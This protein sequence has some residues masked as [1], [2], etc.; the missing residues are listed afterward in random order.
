MILKRALSCG[1][2]TLL[3]TLPT[4]SGCDSEGES[5]VVVGAEAEADGDA[6]KKEKKA[7]L[8]AKA[9]LDLET[10]SFMVR[11]QQVNRN[12]YGC[13]CLFEWRRTISFNFA[14]SSVYAYHS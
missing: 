11:K 8:M 4:A 6:E 7:T 10:V 13:F 1:F 9:D 3:L 14:S 5:K 12:R 2:A